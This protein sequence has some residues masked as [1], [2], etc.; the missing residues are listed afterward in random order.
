M[1]FYGLKQVCYYCVIRFHIVFAR[2]R[3][4][5]RDLHC[6]PMKVVVSVQSVI[7]SWREKMG[8]LKGPSIQG[9]EGD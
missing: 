6:N 9:L 8:Q 5:Q 4:M 7:C 3:G 2:L 1:T